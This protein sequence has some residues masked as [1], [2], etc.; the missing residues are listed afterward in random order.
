[1]KK[2][3]GIAYVTNNNNDDNSHNIT[4]K[5]SMKTT[6][7]T[8]TTTTTTMTMMMTM[9]IIMKMIMMIM[10]T[11]ANEIFSPWA[12]IHAKSGKLG[13]AFAFFIRLSSNFAGW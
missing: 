2:W 5:M 9:T 4:I 10:L 12:R 13:T 11:E 8:M 3:F 7:M 6:T 1:M